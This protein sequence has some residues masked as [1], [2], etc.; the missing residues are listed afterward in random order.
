MKAL[1]F[2]IFS[3]LV[4]SACGGSDSSSSAPAELQYSGLTSAATISSSNA[5]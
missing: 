3:A 5:E 2:S 1:I 4:I